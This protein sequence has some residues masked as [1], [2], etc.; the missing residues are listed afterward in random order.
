MYSLPIRTLCKMT[1]RA[2]L[3]W[4][5]HSEGLGRKQNAMRLLLLQINASGETAGSHADQED[6]RIVCSSNKFTFLARQASLY[7]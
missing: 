1:R 6:P 4:R 7:D 2:G 3:E 5:Q